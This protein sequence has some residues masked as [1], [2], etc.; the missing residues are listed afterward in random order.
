MKI[1]AVMIV[2]NEEDVVKTSIEHLQRFCSKIFVLDNGSSDNTLNE[3]K[4]FENDRV[5][6][7]GTILPPFSDRMKVWVWS[8]VKHVANEGD[9]WLFADAD[10]FYFD[11]VEQFLSN[12]PFHYGV[13]LKRQIFPVP[14]DGQ[15][16]EFA[17]LKDFDPKFFTHYKRSNWVEAR[18]FRHTWRLQESSGSDFLK[19]TRAI[20]DTPIRI[21]HY[22][23]RTA[24]QVTSRIA[25]RRELRGVSDTTFP[26]VREETWHD[27]FKNQTEIDCLFNLR[28]G[29]EWTSVYSN[30]QPRSVMF[31]LKNSIR[32]GL[33]LIGFL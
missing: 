14:I 3:I 15:Q 1:F 20:Y 4:N 30:W 25:T 27:I 23:Y 28:D 24:A 8:L 18:F 10:E 2:K 9:W 5:V 21:F 17:S 31:R 22:N 26:H 7:L 32:I 12:I 13:V 16:N 33:S 29:P 6:F 19:W 11:A